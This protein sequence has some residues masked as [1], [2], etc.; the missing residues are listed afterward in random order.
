[1]ANIVKEF[2]TVRLTVRPG[3]LEECDQ[4]VPILKSWEEQ[5]F[6]T[7]RTYICEEYFIKAI[8]GEN[9]PAN[10]SKENASFMSIR[11][12]GQDQIIGFLEVYHGHPHEKTL[13]IQ[14]F[15]VDKQCRGNKMGKEIIDELSKQAKEKGFSKLRIGVYLKDWT[16]LR[17]WASMGFDRVTGIHGD[18]EYRADTFALMGLEKLL[19]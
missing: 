11:Q 18:T 16:A 6:V 9:I 15:V 12:K 5:K 4:L 7:G 17:F 14:L 3:T 2:A 8:N 10:G 19:N 13:W 1:M